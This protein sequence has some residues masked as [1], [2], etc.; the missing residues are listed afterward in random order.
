MVEPSRSSPI[1]STFNDMGI[2]VYDEAPDADT[3]PHFPRPPGR[4]PDEDAE[5]RRKLRFPRST[6]NIG[7]NHR[8]GAHVHGAK[9]DRSSSSR[10]KA[11]SEIAKRI[12]TA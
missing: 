4:V 3:L 2:Q 5:R 1:I 7:R 11:R 9:W 8:P 12:E 10:A 6:P